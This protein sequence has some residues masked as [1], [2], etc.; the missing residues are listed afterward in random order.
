MIS[1]IAK[2]PSL[3]YTLSEK[4]LVDFLEKADHYYYNT[5]KAAIEDNIYDIAK[6]RL[7]L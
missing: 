5:K 2:K 1:K 6:E 7:Q 3:I 4:N